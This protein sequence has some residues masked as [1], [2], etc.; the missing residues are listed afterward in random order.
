[1]FSWIR[2]QGNNDSNVMSLNDIQTWIEVHENNEW[3][4]LTYTGF[5]LETPNV[6]LGI[7]INRIGQWII[8]FDVRGTR[9]LPNDVLQLSEWLG[10]KYSMMS[11]AYHIYAINKYRWSYTPQWILENETEDRF[12]TIMTDYYHIIGDDDNE[13]LKLDEQ[14][15]W[16][17]ESNDNSILNVPLSNDWGIDMVSSEME[18]NDMFNDIKESITLWNNSL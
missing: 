13:F 9:Q 7:I 11:N 16:N 17:Y 8:S 4:D 12:Q 2:Q 5:L 18:V 3:R 14:T 15:W 1:M 10:E 6:D